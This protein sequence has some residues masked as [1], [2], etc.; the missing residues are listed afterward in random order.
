MSAAPGDW[1]RICRFVAERRQGQPDALWVLQLLG[2]GAMAAAP[3]PDGGGSM[4]AQHQITADAY[5]RGF[6]D[7]GAE[8]GL[9]A[10]AGQAGDHWRLLAVAA[11][12]RDADCDGPEPRGVVGRRPASI[13]PRGMAE[14]VIWH[15]IT[16]ARWP[17]ALLAGRELAQLAV[18][19]VEAWAGIM[20]L[21]ASGRPF[22]R[23][24]E[25]GTLLFEHLRRGTCRCGGHVR[26]C[27]RSRNAG[28]SGK[29]CGRRCCQPGHAL[30]A[31][32]PMTWEPKKNTLRHFVTKAITGFLDLDSFGGGTRPTYQY[33]AAG[34]LPSPLRMIGNF[35]SSM[36]FGVVRA[37]RPDIGGDG[38]SEFVADGLA[39]G[40][41][42]RRYCGYCGKSWDAAPPTAESSTEPR[43][44]CP[45]CDQ[46]W[47]GRW[48]VVERQLVSAR[49]HQ[50]VAAWRC[51]EDGCREIAFDR[52]TARVDGH[53]HDPPPGAWRPVVVNVRLGPG[54]LL[55]GERDGWLGA[56][57]LEREDPEFLVVLLRLRAYMKLLRYLHM[58]SEVIYEMFAR[59]F[60]LWRRWVEEGIGRES[61]LAGD[62]YIYEKMFRIA[63]SDFQIG[64]QELDIH[65][66]HFPCWYEGPLAL[67]TCKCSPPIAPA[68]VVDHYGAAAVAK[69]ILRGNGKLNDPDGL[70]WLP[71]VDDETFLAEMTK[72]LRSLAPMR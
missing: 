19:Q 62:R 18:R 3:D 39:V 38:W 10:T 71:E 36:A 9:P 24:D 55:L 56:L 4:A 35:G 14:A 47:T 66:G 65:G 70:A 29:V 1:T 37:D 40:D 44:R 20:V 15:G 52:P 49:D 41:V 25:I 46:P 69:E 48:K 27:G 28:S 34:D 63:A 2:I 64:R 16:Q 31:W 11:F 45:D 59:I 21:G 72:S 33:P 23:P 60:G 12:D 7:L 17:L 5:L 50:L 54:E 6:L 32:G 8:Y 51:G 61:I 30:R 22:D 68:D 43:T 42:A 67:K 57:G 53:E 13:T 26:G 58:S